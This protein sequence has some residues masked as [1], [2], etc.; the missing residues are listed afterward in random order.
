[1]SATSRLRRLPH[2]SALFF[3]LKKGRSAQLARHGRCAMDG[4]QYYDELETLDP[5]EREGRLFSRL[6]RFLA[7]LREEMPGWR[8]RL[9]GIDV[10]AVRDRAALARLPVLRKSE[11][12]ELQV[13]MPPFGGLSGGRAARA[14]MSPGPIFE[15]QSPSPDA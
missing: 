2:L 6:P 4:S 11:L 8:S 5:H 1:M 7:H 13:Q 9:S 14:F 15:P 10:D 12:T 3:R